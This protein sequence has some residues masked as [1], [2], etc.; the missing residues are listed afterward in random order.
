MTLREIRKMPT[1]LTNSELNKW[2]DGG[3]T[4][5]HESLLRS[6][7]IVEKVKELLEKQVAPQVIL[8]IIED[9][10]GGW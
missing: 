6:F 2:K 4:G 9:L 5:V 7:H 8:E 3:S 10:K 1:I